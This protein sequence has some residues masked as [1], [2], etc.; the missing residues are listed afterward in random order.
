LELFIGVERELK[1]K[2]GFEIHPLSALIS[3][4]LGV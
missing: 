3:T 1:K 2:G 4:F